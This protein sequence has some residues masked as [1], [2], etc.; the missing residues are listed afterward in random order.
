VVDKAIKIIFVDDDETFVKTFNR[1]ANKKKI[2]INHFFTAEEAKHELSLSTE[3][4]Y[5]GIVLDVKGLKD[6]ESKIPDHSY[7]PKALMELKQLCPSLQVYGITGETDSRDDWS[8]TFKELTTIYSKELE[9]IN[10]LLAQ[11]K[12]DSKK[13]PHI[14]L[15]NTYKQTFE[16]TDKILAQV[17][18]HSLLHALEY[19]DKGGVD[20]AK[21]LSSLR[22]VLEAIVK[23]IN[24]IRPE[25]VPT[26]YIQGDV[27][28]RPLLRHLRSD[29]YLCSN[30]DY[31]YKL[32]DTAY[33]CMSNH[34]SHISNQ[35][36]YGSCHKPAGINS[37]R[38]C[39]FAIM[40]IIEWSYSLNN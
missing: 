38:M 9:D 35:S 19:K 5:A 12:D 27:K 22:L 24:T 25:V 1:E 7:F 3:K 20:I 28:F 31:L 15:M 14:K 33:T 8:E 11:L 10:K 21:V 26:E 17:E 16:K 29:N 40:D 36:K 6:K 32:L 2:I 4:L 30:N 34:G 18:Q 37:V 23:Y 13:I 39:T